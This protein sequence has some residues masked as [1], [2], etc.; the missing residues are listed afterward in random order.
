MGRFRE[1]RSD[2]RCLMGLREVSLSKPGPPLPRTAPQVG[3]QQHR[4][5]PDQVNELV[6]TYQA[7]ATL[8][9]LAAR[10][11]LHRVTVIAHLDRRKVARRP[12]VGL[13]PA[14]ARGAVQLYEDGLSISGIGVRLGFSPN[15]VRRY[16]VEAGVSIRPRR[17]S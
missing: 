12:P 16:L 11:S 8:K 17:G 13:S 1:H 6:A 14:Q 9:A 3:Q 2:L 5:N 15:T 4:L 10:F 7:G